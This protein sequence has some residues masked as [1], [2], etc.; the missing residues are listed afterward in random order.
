MLAL[1]VGVAAG[2]EFYRALLH[3]CRE[4]PALYS[5]DFGKIATAQPQAA[6]AFWRHAGQNRAVVVL[7]LSD[8]AQRETLDLSGVAGNY[9][10]VFTGQSKRLTGKENLDLEPWGYRVYLSGTPLPE[11]HSLK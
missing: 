10:E 9:R 11:P 6:Y 2:G 4:N 5:G 3:A 8:H 7:N 1:S